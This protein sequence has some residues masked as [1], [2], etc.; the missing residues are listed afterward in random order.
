MLTR[1]SYTQPA[2]FNTVKFAQHGS[3]VLVLNNTSLQA[4]NS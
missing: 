3:K 1:I 4:G 2:H